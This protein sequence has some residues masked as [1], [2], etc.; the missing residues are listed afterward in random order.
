LTGSNSSSLLQKSW[1]NYVILRGRISGVEGGMGDER[2][3]DLPVSQAFVYE[4]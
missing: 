2:G 3:G 4:T 1:T